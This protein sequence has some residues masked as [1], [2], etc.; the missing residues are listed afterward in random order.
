MLIILSTYLGFKK[1]KQ[2]PLRLI[3]VV[4]FVLQIFAAVGLTGYLSLRNGQKA[5]NELATQLQKN[6]SDRVDQH[7]DSYLGIPHQINQLNARAINLGLID[8]KDLRNFGRYFWQQMR[9]FKEFGYINF[10]NPQGDF[11]GIYRAPDDSLRM[12]F[13]EQA[14]LGQY[15][16]YATD[17]KGNP[18]KR[19]IEDQFD[20]RVDN[21]YTDAIKY[22]RPLWSEIY[23]WDDD[24]SIISVSASYPLYAQDKKLIGVIGIDLVLSQIGDFLKQLQV[25][26]SAKTYILERNGLIVAASSD[27]KF[28]TIEKGEAQRM[29]ASAS[30]DPTLRV[31]FTD[32]NQRFGSLNSIKNAQKLEIA[33]AGKKTFVL[34]TPWQDKYGLNWLVV[35]AIPETDF[36]AQINANTR[37]TILLCLGALGVATILG[38]YTS[39]W[40][41]KPILRL[42]QASGAIASGDLERRVKVRGINELGTLADSFNHMAQQLQ[43]SF[44]ALG[45]TNAELETRVEERTVELKVAIEAAENAKHTADR[46]NQAKSDFLANM[47]H[48]LRTPLNGILGY[49]QILQRSK[50]SDSEDGKGLEIIYQCGSHLLTLIDD[51]LDI[52]KIEAQKMELHP[53]DFHFPSFLQGVAEIC[54]IRAEQK[55]IAFIFQADSQLPGG[56]SAD[57]KRLRQVL[58]NLIGNAIKFTDLGGVTFKVKKLATSSKLS[59]PKIRFQVKDTGVGIA[60]TQIQK[61]FL[62]FEQVGDTARMA[63]GTGLGLAISQKII[64]MM[65]STIQVKSHPYQGS[66]FW[67]DVEL[68]EAKQWADTN[69]IGTGGKIIG[70]NGSTRKILVVDD[71]WEN[72]S[73]L[74][75][76]LRPIGF[77]VTEANN[78][79]E[80]LEK[81]IAIAPDLIISDL[82]MPVMDGFEMMRQLRKSPQLQNI[83]LVT[84][85]ASVFEID[86]NKSIDAG[87]DEFLPK[88]VQAEV[89][90][91]VLRVHLQLQWI[92]EAI[93]ANLTSQINLDTSS[94]EAVSLN[95]ATMIAPSNTELSRLYDL[96]KQGS[97]DE[98]Q[99]IA[100]QLQQLDPSFQAFAQELIDLTASFQIKQLQEFIEY[101]LASNSS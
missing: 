31:I 21:W 29:K 101:H 7:L 41:A 73:V 68:P 2:V 99:E 35:S 5:V 88:P 50:I 87:A 92:Y 40:I 18:T 64:Q 71:R 56:I 54:R 15:Y 93:D 16:G 10:G 75:N 61:I 28:Y 52:S 36:M 98:I 38:I 53:K 33:I 74:V 58:I 39:R 57:E 70:F 94:S 24:P 47:S 79:Q 20:F 80:G 13:I 11:I 6:V 12:D 86:R 76:L 4:P 95:I 27:E 43:E 55:Q 66:V 1:S 78:G 85:S 91:E 45:Q 3:L 62:P 96:A 19:I 49:A 67:F 81:A 44:T 63:E 22:G 51:I 90:L 60:E 25:S 100:E 84:S 32:L 89:L 9:T 34:V 42:S 77:D 26:P 69:R 82:V 23:T 37:T 46:A 83:I 48:E 30:K 97:L 59:S 72:R 17:A 14:Y 8:T 65:D